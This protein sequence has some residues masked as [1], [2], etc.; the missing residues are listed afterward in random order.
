MPEFNPL[1]IADRELIRLAFLSGAIELTPDAG[2]WGCSAD[3]ANEVFLDETE[4]G[5]PSIGDD[6]QRRAL[7]AIICERIYTANRR[8]PSTDKEP[9]K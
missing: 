2:W 4:H 9:S 7:Y 1:S 3:N 6:E 8:Q 5:L